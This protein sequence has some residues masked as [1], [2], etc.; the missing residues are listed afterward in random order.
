M[1]PFWKR[2][3]F[4]GSLIAVALLGYCV[5]DLRWT[6][7][8]R[9]I[10]RLDLR[11]LI[12]SIICGYVFVISKAQRWRLLVAPHKKIP[13]MRLVSIYSA[14]QVLNIAMPALTGQVGRVI[15]FA[16]YEGLRKTFVFSTIVLEVLFDAVSLVVFL[17]LTS[18]AFVFPEQYRSL[19]IIVASV[20]LL[21]LILLY[22]ILHYRLQ[23]ENLGRRR[24]R[25]RWPGAYVALT[26]FI[27][28]F[29]KG[30]ET[31]RSTQYFCGALALS[32]LVWTSHVL[33]IYFL[34][35]SFGYDLPLAAAAS[36]MIINTI[37]LMVPITPGNAGTFEVAVSTSLTAFSVGRADAVLLAVAL[38]LLDLLPVITLGSGFLRAEK[39]SIRRLKQQDHPDVFDDDSGE[40]EPGR[41]MVGQE[42][43][44]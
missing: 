2:K 31:L 37:A 33:V 11:Y 1:K 30:I 3:R 5:K 20:T 15:L 39:E 41:I 23:L 24:L 43:K 6:D 12:P 36:V 38:H 26:K 13:F 10:N 28:S 8:E 21:A 42:G 7:L 22:G 16:R 25:D 9:M 32:L 4:W 44:A 35:L 18:V 40:T 19:S 27:R 34:L 29:T 17:L 14:G